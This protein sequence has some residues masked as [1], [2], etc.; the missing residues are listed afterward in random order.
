MDISQNILK[1]E[2][3]NSLEMNIKKLKYNFITSEGYKLIGKNNILFYLI[4]LSFLTGCGYS[5]SY[6]AA[7]APICA[8]F[9]FTATIPPGAPSP[10]P[11]TVGPVAGLPTSLTAT[12]L[13]ITGT[14]TGNEFGVYSISASGAVPGA[15]WYRSSTWSGSGIITIPSPL[16]PAPGTFTIQ[17]F[18]MLSNTVVVTI[19]PA[20][21]YTMTFALTSQPPGNRFTVVQTSPITS[22][23]A[24]TVSF[25]ITRETNAPGN[26]TLEVTISTTGGATP[27]VRAIPVIGL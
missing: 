10:P 25:Q 19:T 1:F 8:P 24:G 3:V 18:A 22:T 5:T 15:P 11:P 7:V 26:T 2:Y 21:A 12:G 23:A 27:V 17:P 9:T 6:T 4:F 13:T 20:C 14:P 16:I